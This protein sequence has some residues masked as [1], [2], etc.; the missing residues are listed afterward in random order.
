MFVEVAAAGRA[1]ALVTGNV[2]HFPIGRLRLGVSV[3]TPRQLIEG[4]RRRR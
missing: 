2:R 1:D 3:V 4:L